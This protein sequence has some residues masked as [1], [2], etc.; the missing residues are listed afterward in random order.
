VLVEAEVV[1]ESG[2]GHAEGANAP[3]AGTDDATPGLNPALSREERRN[4]ALARLLAQVEAGGGTVVI[5]AQA[6]AADWG[7]PL[8][9][10][11]AWLKH[12]ADKGA[13]HTRSLGPR[14]TSIEWGRVS[15]A[16]A[17]RARNAATRAEGAKEA[18]RRKS[19][20]TEFCVWCGAPSRVQ[21]ARFCGACGQ[22]LPR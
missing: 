18:P 4:E 10:V 9:T 12:W 13:I 16:K 11:R 14:G 8:V 19:A 5:T 2:G 15:K 3:E 21:G 22:E 20:A 17:T 6:L 7:V 1:E